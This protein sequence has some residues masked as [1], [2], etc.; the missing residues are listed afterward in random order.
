[1]SMT[2]S[3]LRIAEDRRASGW[4]P[5]YSG[6][7]SAAK[8]AL[9]SDDRFVECSVY[10]NGRFFKT[11][12]KDNEMTEQTYVIDLPFNFA[13]DHEDRELPTGEFVKLLHNTIRY[14]CTAPELREWLSDAEFYSNCATSGA[15]WSDPQDNRG[16]QDSARR[17]GARVLKVMAKNGGS[18][19]G[20]VAEF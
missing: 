2:Y 15:G 1:M 16:L 11:I 8:K 3:L 5:M 6:G 7:L 20:P 4:S 17:T 14:R 9:D 13:Y 12:R 10:K 19:E 18:R